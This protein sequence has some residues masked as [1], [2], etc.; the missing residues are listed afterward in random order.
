MKSEQ[1]HMFFLHYQEEVIQIWDD[2]HLEWERLMI[3][4]LYFDYV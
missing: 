1:P 3:E 2:E 4:S